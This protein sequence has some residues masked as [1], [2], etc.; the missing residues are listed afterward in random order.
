MVNLK[1]K[2]SLFFSLIV[3]LGMLSIAS[4]LIKALHLKG[5]DSLTIATGR[6]TFAALLIFPFLLASR[7]KKLLSIP[8]H[9]VGI[10]AISGIILANHFLCWIQSI[11]Y[12]SIAESTALVTTTPIWVGI[13]SVLFL[14][15][16]ISIRF[17]WGILFS[18]L[19]SLI[20]F[21]SGWIGKPPE[22]NTLGYLLATTGAILMACYLLIGQRLRNKISLMKY[23]FLTNAFAAFFLMLFLIPTGVPYEVFNI[24]IMGLI[25]ILSLGPQ[26]VGHTLI[27]SLA[28][29][30]SAVFVSLIIICEPVGA[31]ILAHVIFGETMPGLTL[32]SFALLILGVFLAGSAVGRKSL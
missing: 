8:H 26:I 17:F 23:I 12:I 29:Q 3:A 30:L 21:F 10:S 18:G 20:M 7:D 22:S 13:F 24:N 31:A 5:V 28:R 11:S 32:I 15:E 14:H 19:G 6:V 25:L 27:I 2:T 16:K 9:I 1:G 4:I